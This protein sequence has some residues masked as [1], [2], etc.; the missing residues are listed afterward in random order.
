MLVLFVPIMQFLLH[1]PSSLTGPSLLTS[2]IVF[3]AVPLLT[4]VMLRS[5]LGGKYGLDG[6]KGFC[7][8]NSHRSRLPC[9]W[10]DFVFEAYVN[11]RKD[12][13]YL[14]GL[15]VVP[16]SRP[17]SKVGWGFGG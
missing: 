1:G 16:E 12:V 5:L 3:I 15:P 6:L 17:H 8:R 14:T 7:C 2:V 9:Y 4:G 13:I 11:H 10:N